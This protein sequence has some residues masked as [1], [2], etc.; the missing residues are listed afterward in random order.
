MAV[1]RGRRNEPVICQRPQSTVQ[2][3]GLSLGT[4]QTRSLTMSCV[5]LRDLIDSQPL[6]ARP[7]PSCDSGGFGVDSH[8]ARLNGRPMS[9]PPEKVSVVDHSPRRAY[10]LR[11]GR[12]RSS[13]P[14][15]QSCDHRVM[16]QTN[17]QA[18]GSSDS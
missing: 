7:S 5:T 1:R 18:G 11:V 9:N 8:S 16:S 17:P 14:D 3:K 10:N 6:T 13:P 15:V 2:V 4:A 12:S